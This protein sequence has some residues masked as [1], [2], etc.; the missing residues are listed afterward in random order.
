[1]NG[2]RHRRRILIIDDEADVCGLLSVILDGAGYRVDLET[3]WDQA[4]AKI[5]AGRP[6]LVFLNVD[7]QGRTPGELLAR[8]A[9]TPS[10]PPLIVA[11]A[12][13]VPPALRGAHSRL[14]WA[15]LSKPFPV[16]VLLQA[17]ERI[18]ASLERPPIAIERRSEP[19]RTLVTEVA[20]LSVEGTPVASGQVLDVS[21][22]GAQ[23][24][25]GVPLAV[26][27]RVRL[28]LALP[29]EAQPLVVTGQVRWHEGSIVGVR[30]LDLGPDAEARLKRLAA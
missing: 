4:V 9:T 19:R 14:V 23:V 26:D 21:V 17:C 20:L 28:S 8:L 5:E 24:D 22:H 13:G 6:D 25:L 2:P 16:G 15:F 11:S 3:D 1:M 29:D 18:C 30:F 7:L 12:R 10:P 27:S